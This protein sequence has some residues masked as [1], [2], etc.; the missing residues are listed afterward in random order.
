[1]CGKYKLPA[2]IEMI[3]TNITC[4]ICDNITRSNCSDMRPIKDIIVPDDSAPAL[5]MTNNRA[6]AV[7]MQWGFRTNDK[8]MI[9][10]ARSE[11][12]NE[13]SMFKNLVNEQRCALPTAG[14]FEWRDS[15]KL[16]HLISES[17]GQMFYLAGLYRYDSEGILR[18]VV[19]TRSAYDDHAKLHDRMP[20]LLFSKEEARRW[21]SG[22]LAIEVF[23]SRRGENLKIEVQEPEQLYMQFDD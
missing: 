22:E 16:R 23:A 20:C 15:D 18:F 21:V 12:V 19:L 14:Y 13:K 2:G 10:N 5:I 9:I 6:K 8:K 1:M 7:L 4:E 3:C 17:D 11:T